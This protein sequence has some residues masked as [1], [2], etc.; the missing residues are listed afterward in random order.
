MER[1]KL[2]ERERWTKVVERKLEK[3]GGMETEVET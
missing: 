1:A 3:A 2:V